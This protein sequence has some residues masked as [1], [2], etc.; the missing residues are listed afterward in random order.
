MR[1]WHIKQYIL[2]AK[3]GVEA[4][5]EGWESCPRAVVDEGYLTEQVGLRLNCKG[6][7][8]EDEG[9]HELRQRYRN[10]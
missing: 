6:W 7:P 2:I 1:Q 10:A 3:P 5:S 8:R 4:Q 9:P